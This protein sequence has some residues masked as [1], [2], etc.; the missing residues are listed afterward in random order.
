MKLFFG[1]AVF[2]A[3]GYALYFKY[4]ERLALLL[5]KDK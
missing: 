1:L 4:G 5:K 2:A 3:V